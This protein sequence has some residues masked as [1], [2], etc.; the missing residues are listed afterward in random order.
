MG[1]RPHTTKAPENGMICRRKKKLSRS[2]S[3]KTLNKKKAGK[4]YGK[5]ENLCR[6][7]SAVL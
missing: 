2:V 7:G 6:G 5:N 3:L 1:F 4:G